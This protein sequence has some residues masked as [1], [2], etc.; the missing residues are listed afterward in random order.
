ME[1]V[2]FEQGPVNVDGI[3]R[4]GGETVVV[5]WEV[6]ILEEGVGFLNAGDISPIVFCGNYYSL[7][8]WF[9]MERLYRAKHVGQF[10]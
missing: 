4:R 9:F 6:D 3:G 1:P 7:V 2:G 10:I 5:R 8:I